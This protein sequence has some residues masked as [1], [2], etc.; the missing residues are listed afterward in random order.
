LADSA[1][2][3]GDAEEFLAALREFH[4]R[5]CVYPQFGEP[6]TDLTREV[7]QIWIGIVHPLAMRY[8]VFDERRA[9]MVTGI[10]VLL[11]K[12]EPGNSQ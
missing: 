5:L 3:R 12:S 4:R 9:V 6:L 2:Q 1:S 8:G 10:P 11:R 7:G